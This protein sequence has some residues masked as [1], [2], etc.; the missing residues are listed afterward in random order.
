MFSAWPIWVLV[1]SSGLLCQLLKLMLYSL[2]KRRL[3]LAL[4]ARGSGLPSLQ[5][6][7]LACLLVLVIARSGWKS[8]ETAFALVFTVIVVH[9]TMKLTVAASRQREAVYHLVTSLP[10]AGEFHQRV[11][12][13]LDPRLHQVSHVVVGVVFGGLFALALGIGPG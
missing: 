13:F 9:D 3:D 2:M 8:G 5:A 10:E 1:L 6:T 4:I 11:A 12:G 7:L